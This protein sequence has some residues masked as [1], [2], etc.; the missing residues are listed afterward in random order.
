MK[1]KDNNILIYHFYIYEYNIHV[2]IIWA[3]LLPIL[4]EWLI[5]R[6]QICFF[7]CICVDNI[8]TLRVCDLYIFATRLY[9]F[10]LS[11]N[12]NDTMNSVIVYLFSALTPTNLLPYNRIIFLLFKAYVII[13]NIS[14]DF[15]LAKPY[16]KLIKN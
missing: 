11:I 13:L 10:F 14:N 8:F 1:K 6:C 4:F 2:I 9:N 3:M 16:K 12:S 5:I 7:G 15:M